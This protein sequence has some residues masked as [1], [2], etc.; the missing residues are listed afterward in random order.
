M[1]NCKLLILRKISTLSAMIVK[2]N[3]AHISFLFLNSYDQN[4]GK[5]LYYIFK[6][7]DRTTYSLSTFLNEAYIYL[8]ACDDF[9]TLP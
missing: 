6:L 4:L 9:L 2:Y 7:F 1:F 3:L 8:Y 5:A